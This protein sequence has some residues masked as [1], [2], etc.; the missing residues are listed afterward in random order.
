MHSLL[1]ILLEHWWGMMGIRAVHCAPYGG[2]GTFC[3]H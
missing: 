1:E 3:Q 2:L